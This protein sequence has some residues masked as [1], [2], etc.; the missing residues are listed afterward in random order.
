MRY[1][2]LESLTNH[3]EGA[4]VEIRISVSDGDSDELESLEV[5]LRGERGLAGRVRLAGAQPREGELG[6]LSDALVVAVGS[7]GAI[8][9]L[10]A[11][12]KTW[13][14]LPRRSDVRLHIHRADGASVE[15]DAKR[16]AA[17]LIDIESI[18][19]QTLEL[20]P[21]EE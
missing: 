2:A 3:R 17:G 8:S 20:G 9:M 19:R 6:T 10:A 14:S 11:A 4:R 7:G 15:I 5:W 21:A 12:V 18:I 13:L 1:S 16:V